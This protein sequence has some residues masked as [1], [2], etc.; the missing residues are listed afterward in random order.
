MVTTD[1]D[2]A[3]LEILPLTPDRWDDVAALFG[4]GGDPKSCSC[5]FW[6]VRSK[7][8]NFGNRDEAREGF[9]RLVDEDRDPAPGLL[10]YRD[11]RAVG[12]VSVAPR[13]DYERLTA[14]RVRPK[15]DDVAVWSVVCFVV[16]KSERGQGL[17]SRLLDAATA[18]AVDHGAPGLEAYPVDPGDG[19]VPAALGYTGLL[20]TFEAAGFEVVHEI[21]SPQA[22]VRRVIVRRL[23]APHAKGR[24]S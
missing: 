19:R 1:S 16:S 14:S 23:L 17:T 21:D 15:I 22:T 2:A 13:D 10:A 12:W 24:G 3:E 9:H 8:W 5:M 4:E 7:D 20:S 18:Y 11:G 6:R